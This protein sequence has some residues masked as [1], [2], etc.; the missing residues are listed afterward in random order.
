[1]PQGFGTKETANKED[2]KNLNFDT[3][4]LDSFVKQSSY[5]KVG[6]IQRPPEPYQGIGRQKLN[7]FMKK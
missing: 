7:A 3:K 4:H 5:G 1:M 6:S 2:V